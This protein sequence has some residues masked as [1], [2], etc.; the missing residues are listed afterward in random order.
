MTHFIETSSR[1]T[2]LDVKRIAQIEEI[3]GFRSTTALASLTFA[4]V[5]DRHAGAGAPSRRASSRSDAART[6]H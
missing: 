3:A 1:S 4:G 5:A 2:L 6:L